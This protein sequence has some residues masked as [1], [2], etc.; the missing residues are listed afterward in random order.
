MSDWNR[1]AQRVQPGKTVVWNRDALGLILLRD[2]DAFLR[3]LLGEGVPFEQDCV[4]VNA[5]KLG[6]FSTT[7]S[8]EI[9]HELNRICGLQWGEE[10]REL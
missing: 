6:Q 4:I 1:V 3:H 9:A 2:A 10:F 7:E 5:Q 8:G